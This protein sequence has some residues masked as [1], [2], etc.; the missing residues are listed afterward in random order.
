MQAGPPALESRR[1][2]S[3]GATAT[4][5]ASAGGDALPRRAPCTPDTHQRKHTAT[6]ARM[7]ALPCCAPSTPMHAHMALTGRHSRICLC[8]RGQDTV[9][10]HLVVFIHV[11][12]LLD[13]V[14]HHLDHA[15]LSRIKERMLGPVLAQR[16]LDLV[17]LGPVEGSLA[18][19]KR[20][21]VSAGAWRGRACMCGPSPSLALPRRTLL[22]RHSNTDA[23]DC[24]HTSPCIPW[25]AHTWH[26]GTRAHT[27][28]PTPAARPRH[29]PC[30]SPR[31]RRRAVAASAPP[32][33]ARK[34]RHS[35]S[36]CS[37]TGEQAC[38]QRRGHSDKSGLGRAE[39]RS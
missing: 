39:V 22:P 13:Q 11:S 30:S 38:G 29:L 37:R 1:A 25:R 18:V 9:Q 35:A 28:T 16:C 14:R 15:L 3:G 32:Q 12:A 4:R 26:A 5:A 23:H 36:W 10:T 7:G 33:H 6:G 34:R 17:V 2:V 21:G 19:L 24:V 8:I 27:A 31:C 20:A